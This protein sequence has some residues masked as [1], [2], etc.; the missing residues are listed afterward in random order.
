MLSNMANEISLYPLG[1][2]PTSSALSSD[3]Q[4]DVRD[5]VYAMLRSL[6]GTVTYGT[7]SEVFRL[8]E[9]GVQLGSSDFDTAP[10]SVTMAGLL[11]ATGASISGTITATAGTIGGFTLSATTLTATN[12]ILDSAGQR[13][14]LG[15]G[16][17]IVILDA[18]DATYRAWIGHTTAASAPFSVTKAGAVFASAGT[19]AGW[20]LAPST[21]TSA[22]GGIVLSDTAETIRVGSGTPHILIDGASGNIGTSSF[23]SGLVGWRIE[24]TGDAEFNN[25]TARGEFHTQVLSYGEVH[26]TAG[27]QLWSKSAG[28]LK[29]DVA[30]L[31]SPSTFNV[32]IDDPDT[33]H[34]Q[35]FST[36]DILRIKDG[37]GFDN[38]LTI[39]SVSDQTTFYRYVCTKNS[40][41]NTTFRAGAAVVDYGASGQGAAMLT[42]DSANSPY[43]SIFTHAGSP[44]SALTEKVRLGNLAG[45]TDPIFG[46]LSGYGLWTDNVYLTGS[47]FASAGRFGTSTNYWNISS[48]SLVATGSGDVALRAGQTDYATGTGFWLGLKSGTAKF[49]IGNTTDY[50]TWDGSVLTIA[51]TLSATAG[52]IGGFSIGAD[53]IR[54]TANTFGLSSTVTGGDDVRFWAGDTFANRSTAPLR[55][56][57]SGKLYATGAVVNGSTL[58]F[59]DIYGDGSDGNVT[60]SMDTTLTR[61][62]FY[63]SLTVN[64]GVS[65]NTGS[66]RIFCRTSLTNN[67]TIHRNGNAG[68]NGSTGTGGTA[69]AAL[70]DGSLKGSVAGQAGPSVRNTAGVAG[71]SAAKSLGVVGAAGGSGDNTTGADPAGG[72]AGAKTGAVFNTPRNAMAAYL[73]YDFL[74]SGDNLRSSAG[75]GSGASGDFIGG[76]NF[77]GGGGSASPGGIVAIYSKIITNTGTISANGANGGNGGNGSSTAG[78]SGGGGGGG[79]GSSGGVILLVYSSLTNSGSLSVAG[80]TGGAAGVSSFNGTLGGGTAAAGGNGSTG[81]VIQLQI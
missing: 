6:D 81:V 4:K 64:N 13:I 22:S 33:G 23:A 29:S 10:F 77:G 62:M 3:Q 65:L 41:T 14:S 75:S 34:I 50:L 74:P 38:W 52:T 2:L 28:K 19:I 60:I 79:G 8:S 44:W 46:S 61:D 40:G 21:L 63:D 59:E 36:G 9:R 73:L 57:E 11:R 5:L 80:G 58:G 68:G 18:D 35:V 53:Y 15:S 39:S 56:T 27:T 47:V 24:K 67:G 66:F 30:T 72:A 17:D 76:G 55:I 26:A 7:V 69:G 43:L 1:E 25:L 12:L 54:D 37:S 51:G 78:N 48:S 16:N 45:I 32:D 49:S 42:V 71:T 20:D 70:A 31:T